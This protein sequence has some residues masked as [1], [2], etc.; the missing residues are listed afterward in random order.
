MNDMMQF[1][2]DDSNSL[3]IYCHYL[4]VADFGARG[5]TRA[6]C[7]TY[8]TPTPKKIQRIFSHLKRAFTETSFILKKAAQS[9]FL[10][11]ID[12][13]IQMIQTQQN[14][15]EYC[16]LFQCHLDATNSQNILTDM[17]EIRQLF[18]HKLSE[19]NAP[20]TESSNLDFTRTRHRPHRVGKEGYKPLR[21]LIDRNQYLAFRDS[22]RSHHSQFHKNCHFP[23]TKKS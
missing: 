12:E 20:V 8:I 22:L 17:T 10:R 21:D 3:Y 23:K 1:F 16:D 2:E 13:I 6:L 7:L 18:G 14:S 9:T 11:E 4:S 5:Y 15:N 19:N